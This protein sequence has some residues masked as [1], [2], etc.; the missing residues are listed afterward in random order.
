MK[1]GF[2]LIELLVV[3]SILA[4]LSTV[5]FVALNPNKRFV[6]ARDAR[7]FTDV[8][9]VL[10]AVHECIVDNGGSI[11]PCIGTLASGTV[12]EIVFDPPG[13]GVVPTTGCNDVCTAVDQ[14]AAGDDDCAQL[15]INL[16]TYLKSIPTDPG[17][18]TAG[19]A[20][21]TISRNASNMITIAACSAEG[22]T[23]EVSR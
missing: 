11:A 7:R 20:E 5:V 13:A 14:L 15:D 2:T 10:T 1:K 9:N 23:V 3:I 4:I 8:N 16:A 18:T 17:G 6:D 22:T 12:Y 21:Y 19:H